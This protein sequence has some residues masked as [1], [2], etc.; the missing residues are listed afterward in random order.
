MGHFKETRHAGFQGYQCF[1]PLT[2]EKKRWVM[3]CTL[4]CGFV[5]LMFRTIHSVNQLSIFGAV[6]SWCDDLAQ[7]I[8][9]QNELIMEKSVAEEN[10]H[11]LENVKPQEVSSLVQTPRS[12]DGAS[13]HRLREQLQRLRGKYT[14]AV[15]GR[16]LRTPSTGPKLVSTRTSRLSMA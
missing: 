15:G 12:N 11:L 8:L 2:S 3:H 14:I 4:Q 7:R 10:E 1:E 16:T 13:G 6:A 9:G 5:E